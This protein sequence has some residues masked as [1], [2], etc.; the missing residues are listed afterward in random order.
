MHYACP[1]GRGILHYAVL[2]PFVFFLLILWRC[3]PSTPEDARLAYTYGGSLYLSG[4]EFILLI[5]VALLASAI[6]ALAMPTLVMLAS[7]MVSL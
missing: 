2:W 7:A 6:L 1:L 5:P 3:S 4:D